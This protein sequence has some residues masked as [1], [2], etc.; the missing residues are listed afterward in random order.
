MPTLSTMHIPTPTEWNEFQNIVQSALQIR[1]ASSDLQLYGRNGQ[2]QQ[3]VDISGHNDLGQLVGIQCK[4]SKDP[5]K[6]AE[7]A[8]EIAE[9]EKFQPP[10][11]AFYIATTQ[12]LD[13]KLQQK[14]RLLSAQR[15]QNSKFPVQILFWDDIIKSLITNPAI[16]AIHYPQLAGKHSY[17]EIGIRRF[18]LFSLV[19]YGKTLDHWAD[20]IFG[21]FG[22]MANVDSNNIFQYCSLIRASATQV[23]D[24]NDQQKIEASLDGY[25]KIV[26]SILTTERQKEEREQDFEKRINVKWR[27]AKLF[28][29]RIA[30]DLDIIRA[31][32]HEDALA[33]FELGSKLAYWELAEYND[34]RDYEPNLPGIFTVENQRILLQL[35]E[36]VAPTVIDK[37]N[38]RLNAYN[39]DK[40]SRANVPESIFGIIHDALV[41]DELKVS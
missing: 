28:A 27:K 9:A 30:S 25:E 7:I 17:I 36:R 34:N 3:G 29:D 40:F 32:L 41:M 12:E 4:N 39:V 37:A 14:I 18:A 22:H 5:L 33:V 19:F 2:A 1:W 20:I 16:F 21:E 6:D 24:S 35:I 11:A 38:N 23:L 26:K 15:V 8:K 10:I 31:S 13:A